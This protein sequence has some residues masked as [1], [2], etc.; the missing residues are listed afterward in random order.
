MNSKLFFRYKN[1]LEGHKEMD[2]PYEFMDVTKADQFKWIKTNIEHFFVYI[3][4]PV[5][6]I[7]DI[8]HRIIYKPKII[9]WHQKLSV[10]F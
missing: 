10:T 1:K 9:K 8:S 2:K 7:A 6:T 4:K 3:F 5:I